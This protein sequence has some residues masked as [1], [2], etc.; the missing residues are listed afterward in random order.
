MGD[1]GEGEG[2]TWG[3]LAQAAYTALSL[4]ACPKGTLHN[5]RE[6][7]GAGVF[8]LV[9][10]WLFWCFL[11]FFFASTAKKNLLTRRHEDQC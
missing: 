9:C 3:H 4:G 8:F 10:F 7:H 6:P 5:H 11:G 2:T 1:K